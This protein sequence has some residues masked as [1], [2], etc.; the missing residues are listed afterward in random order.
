MVVKPQPDQDQ[1][2]S[3]YCEAVRNMN[4]GIRYKPCKELVQ[5]MGISY[6]CRYFILRREEGK[7]YEKTLWRRS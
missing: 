1:L 5:R 6:V 7:E 4:L 2:G 3:Y